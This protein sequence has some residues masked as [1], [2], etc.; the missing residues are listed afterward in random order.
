MYRNTLHCQAGTE[1]NR[2]KM[3][4]T[5]TGLTSENQQSYQQWRADR[6]SA[7]VCVQLWYVFTTVCLNI[8]EV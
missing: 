3:L 7:P 6:D 5:C 1:T 4:D 8:T 2:D